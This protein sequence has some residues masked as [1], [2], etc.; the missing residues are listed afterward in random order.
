MPS[1]FLCNPV[2][3]EWSWKKIQIEEKTTSSLVLSRIWEHWWWKWFAAGLRLTT[4]N[5]G[6]ITTKHCPMNPSYQKN[7][8]SKVILSFLS[9]ELQ[10]IVQK[11]DGTEKNSSFLSFLYLFQIGVKIKPQMPFHVSLPCFKRFHKK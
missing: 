5:Y 6:M 11:K 1:P 4:S 9:P 8:G 10:L 3:R 2:T 7:S